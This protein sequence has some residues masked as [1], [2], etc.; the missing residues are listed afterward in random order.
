MGRRSLTAYSHT[1]DIL[2]E[3]YVD[4]MCFVCIVFIKKA[5]KYVTVYT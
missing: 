2:K 5:L 1:N 3:M 4:R